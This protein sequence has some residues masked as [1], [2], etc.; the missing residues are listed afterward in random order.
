[1]NYLP[2]LALNHNPP[3]LC[4]VVARITGLSYWCLAICKYF[5][6][7]M[8][9]GIVAHTCNPSYLGGGGRKIVV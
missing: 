5:K 6:R 2:R 9:L 3:V 7:K 8:K 1:M 4:F